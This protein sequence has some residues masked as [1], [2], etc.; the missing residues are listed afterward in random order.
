[1]KRLIM[2]NVL[3]PPKR[4]VLSNCGRK[5][6]VANGEVCIVFMKGL[7]SHTKNQLIESIELSVLVLVPICSKW[8]HIL[9]ERTWTEWCE[10]S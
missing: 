6:F 4:E 10:E 3:V 1:M 5:A 7:L 2:F 8:L 9:L